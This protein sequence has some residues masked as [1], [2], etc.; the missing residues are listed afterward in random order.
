MLLP[1]FL[2]LYGRCLAIPDSQRTSPLPR[3]NSNKSRSSSEHA[4]ASPARLEEL[5]DIIEERVTAQNASGEEEHA[6]LHESSDVDMSEYEAY[7]SKSILKKDRSRKLEK[8]TPPS[9]HRGRDRKKDTKKARSLKF[10]AGSSSRDKT[11]ANHSLSAGGG[12]SGDSVDT[13][14]AVCVLNSSG[15]LV[16]DTS[17]MM[18]LSGTD[19]RSPTQLF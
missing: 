18:E 8:R 3:V 1:I 5:F 11:E 17:D 7:I 10:A 15:S 19:L 12:L 2:L 9:D 4:S 13:S 16:A 6:S 14:R